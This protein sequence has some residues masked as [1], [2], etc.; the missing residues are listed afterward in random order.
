MTIGVQ[1]IHFLKFEDITMKDSFSHQAYDRKREDQMLSHFL[2]RSTCS[3]EHV[4]QH[5]KKLRLFSLLL[6]ND[7]DTMRWSEVSEIIENE[8]SII[9]DEE[10]R[11]R[12]VN[13]SVKVRKRKDLTAT[14]WKLVD[15]QQLSEKR[16]PSTRARWIQYDHRADFSE[17]LLTCQLVT[18]RMRR[19]L[20][21]T[22]LYKTARWCVHLTTQTTS[23]VPLLQRMRNVIGIDMNLPGFCFGVSRNPVLKLFDQ[24]FDV[25][26][27]KQ[28][29]QPKRS[30]MQSI[31]LLFTAKR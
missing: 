19:Y 15:G 3:I 22:Q 14:R 24:K 16:N 25:H 6:K 27:K 2:L 31:L 29:S 5:R 18:Q 17:L 9:W 30:D 13:D 8:R 23:L 7:V 4:S 28:S 12:V 21:M 11:F 1:L 26:N 10:F 20:S